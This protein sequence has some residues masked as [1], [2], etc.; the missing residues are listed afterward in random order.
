[1][2]PGLPPAQMPRCDGLEATRRIRAL[3]AAQ[4]PAAHKAWIIGLTANA[5]DEDRE[6]CL[7]SGMD[8]FLCA[9]A[10]CLNPEP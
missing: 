1:M 6:D 4:G 2:A 3:E 9:P 5:C 8:A 7:R 10:S